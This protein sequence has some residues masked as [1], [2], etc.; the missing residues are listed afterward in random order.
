MIAPI[1]TATY[2]VRLL[3]APD[4][5]IYGAGLNARRLLSDMTFLQP[6]FKGNI[7]YI[8]DSAPNKAGSELL[9]IPIMGIETLKKSRRDTPVLITPERGTQE[10]TELLRSF[11]FEN[12][13]YYNWESYHA[14]IAAEAQI[15]PSPSMYNS[16]KIAEAE[17]LLSDEKSRLVF[18]AKLD[19]WFQ[20]KHIELER[21]FESDQYFPED[22]ISLSK[23]EVFVD[24]GTMDGSTILDFARRTGRWKYIYGFEPVPVSYELTKAAMTSYKIGN[25]QID[26]CAVGAHDG[27]ITMC[28]SKNNMGAHHSTEYDA[29]FPLDFTCALVNMEVG[30]RSLD[31]LAL[32]HPPTFIKMDIEGG[33]LDALKGAEGIIRKHRP[34]L[35]ISAYHAPKHLFEIP[36]LIHQIYPDYK[37]YMR[38]HSLYFETV[39]YAVV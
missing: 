35:A 10:I 3:D 8:A 11:G 14:A 16:Q 6:E 38:Q 1:T 18:R 21:L 30:S 15:T 7:S 5:I 23:N 26:Q 19:S 36:L 32:E 4:V 28:I 24:C 13:Y 33:E 17:S 20:A 22:I 27:T 29:V 25:S 9:G 31:G 39:C 34:K 37:I 12:L 2:S